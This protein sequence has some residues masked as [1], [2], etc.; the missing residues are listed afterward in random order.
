MINEVTSFF[1]SNDML[2]PDSCAILHD[3]PHLVSSDDVTRSYEDVKSLRSFIDSSDML[4]RA[5]KI[6]NIGRALF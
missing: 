2:V 5:I 1:L 6:A 3:Q 4:T